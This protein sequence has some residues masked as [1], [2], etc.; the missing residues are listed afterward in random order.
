MRKPVNSQT[1]A[2]AFA[3]L[4]LIGIIALVSVT[5][6]KLIPLY[7]QDQTVAKILTDVAND[8]ETASLSPLRTW[9][10][11]DSRLSI[12]SVYGIQK[13]HFTYRKKGGITTIAIN[14]N[15]R[16]NLMGNVDLLVSFSRSADLI[17]SDE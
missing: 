17:R 9:Y 3:W 16:K 12:N 8:P 4:A 1:G 14:Y 13:E 15:A 10:A 6:F 2:S 7:I 11:V 5:A